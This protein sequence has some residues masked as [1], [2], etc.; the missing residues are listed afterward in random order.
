MTLTCPTC[1]YA[2]ESVAQ[3]RSRCGSCGRAVSVPR[4]G[5]EERQATY[6]G[7]PGG[8]PRA[9]AGVA[10]IVLI[11]AGYLMIRHAKRADPALQPDGYK[12]WHW[13]LGGLVC[14]GSGCLLGAYAIGMI[15]GGE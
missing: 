12:A 11:G 8:S 2:W 5:V 9:A 1:G 6:E 7:E 13:W 15:G 14:L 4:Y 3:S 10:A